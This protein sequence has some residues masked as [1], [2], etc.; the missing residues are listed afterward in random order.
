MTRLGHPSR[1]ETPSLLGLIGILRRMVDVELLNVQK[2][3][4]SV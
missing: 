3:R 2:N 4:L 1:V